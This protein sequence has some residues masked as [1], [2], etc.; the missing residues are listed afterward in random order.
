M[1]TARM[2]ALFNTNTQYIHTI[3]RNIIERPSIVQ[4]T[5]AILSGAWC[6]DYRN[7]ANTIYAKKNNNNFNF[8]FLR[9]FL[10][11]VVSHSINLRYN[12]RSIGY[13]TVNW[14]DQASPACPMCFKRAR[15]TM[16]WE[17]WRIQDL[18]KGG[19]KRARKIF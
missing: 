19:A 10:L 14:F 3:P 2:N 17:Q 4:L 11:K 16:Q 15:V 6:H 9:D 8:D 13:N 1:H 18:R 5:S 7:Y 12:L